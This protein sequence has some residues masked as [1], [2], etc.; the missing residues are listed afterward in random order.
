MDVVYALKKSGK[1]LYGYGAWESEF[2]WFLHHFIFNSIFVAY[3]SIL[4]FIFKSKDRTV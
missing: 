3:I 1:V 4:I 2:H